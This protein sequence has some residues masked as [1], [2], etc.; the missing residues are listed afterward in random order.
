MGRPIA[1]TVHKK[2]ASRKAGRELIRALIRRRST[3]CIRGDEA[4]D[5]AAFPV[6]DVGPVFDEI[7]REDT[8][9][10]EEAAVG[11]QAFRARSESVPSWN[12]FPSSAS[13]A[14]EAIPQCFWMALRLDQNSPRLLR[15]LTSQ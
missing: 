5:A 9:S 3:W 2:P 8:A 13:I 12:T 14:L 4:A 6:F 15:F 11:V 7:V 1:S 10:S